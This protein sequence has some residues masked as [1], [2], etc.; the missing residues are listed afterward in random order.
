MKKAA[1]TTRKLKKGDYLKYDDFTFKRTG[2]S[3]DMS[4]L[5]I[6]NSIGKEIRNDIKANNCIDKRDLI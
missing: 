5:E 1:I 2:Q 6:I 4:Q 3:S